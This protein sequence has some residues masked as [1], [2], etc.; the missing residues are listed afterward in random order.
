MAALQVAQQDETNGSYGVQQQQL[1][2]IVT[3]TP[4][5]RN[6]PPNRLLNI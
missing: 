6:S 2:F 1:P 4:E 5:A 3:L